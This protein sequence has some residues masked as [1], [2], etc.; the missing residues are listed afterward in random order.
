MGRRRI[1]ILRSVLS[2]RM[3][4]RRL[5]LPAAAALCVLALHALGGGAPPAS[6][7]A[8]VPADCTGARWVASWVASPS[9]AAGG[10]FEAQ[11]LRTIVTPHLGG[12]LLRLRLSNRFGTQSVTFDRVTIGRRLAGAAV[13]AATLRP[14]T[15]GGSPAVSVPGGQ[16]AIS[17]PVALTFN[18]FDDLA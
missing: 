10:G 13:V 3:P 7:A 9:D 4:I 12:G 17:D 1:G 15:F 11:T 16:E 14:V 8:S 2:A 18:A 5:T 6:G